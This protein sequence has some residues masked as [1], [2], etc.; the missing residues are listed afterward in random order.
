MKNSSDI[1][2]NQTRD[3]PACSAVPRPTAPP[4]APKYRVKVYKRP[5][6]EADFY[7]DIVIFFVIY[8][9]IKYKF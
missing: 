6:N 8:P 9:V 3:L 5:D 2:E 4:R 1:I 7:S